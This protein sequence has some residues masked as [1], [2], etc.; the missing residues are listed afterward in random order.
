MPPH[1]NH[2][3]QTKER[4]FASL[5]LHQAHFLDPYL[6]KYK[7]RLVR[8]EFIKTILP[9]KHK[10]VPVRAANCFLIKSIIGVQVYALLG[11]APMGSP[12]NLKGT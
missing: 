1:V 8:K 7:G 10:C 12:K 4:I 9:P 11:F 6:K 3:C 5:P 2:L